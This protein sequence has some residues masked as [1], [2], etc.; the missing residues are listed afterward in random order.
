M[1]KEEAA[2]VLGCSV[3]SVPEEVRAKYKQLSMKL[4]PDRPGGSE[5]KFV[6][7]NKAY[8]VL[9]EKSEEKEIITKDVFE[10]F[11]MV[12]EQSEE[13]K[14]EIIEL[15]KKYKGSM[16]KI[17]NNLLLG[18]DEQEGRY[19]KIID[20]AI[21]QKK[22]QDYPKYKS[23]P[24]MENKKRQEKRAKEREAAEVLAKVLEKRG[25]DRKARYNA[26]IEKLEENISK[27]TKKKTKK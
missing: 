14:E 16:V 6:E 13:E 17:I 22:V 25:S 24:L 11:R 7:L 12:Y 10:R 1:R 27:N 21:E 15:Y 4:H 19:R 23:K 9:M 20:E 26:M 18:E 2:K 3:E 5:I 8:E